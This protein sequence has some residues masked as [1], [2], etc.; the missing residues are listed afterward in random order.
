M[1]FLESIWQLVEFGYLMIMVA[2]AFQL[3]AIIIQK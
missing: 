3:M 2:K 1:L